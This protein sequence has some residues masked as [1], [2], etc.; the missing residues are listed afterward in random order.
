MK[1]ILGLCSALLYCSFAAHSQQPTSKPLRLAIAGLS[2]GHVHQI[3]N[4]PDKGDI[5][6]V[7]IY[8]SNRKLVD[9]YAKQ[10]GFRE[11][12]VFGDLNRM[13]DTVKPTA[14][15]AFGPTYDH[16][17]V[18]QACA[19]RGIHVMVEKPLAADSKQAFTIEALAKKAGIH[20]LTN[21]ETTWYP[22]T[23]A[24]FD[25]VHNQ[26]GIGAIRKIVV[27][28]GHQGPKEIGVEEEFLAWLTDPVLNGGGAL[29]DFGCYGANLATWLMNGVEPLTVTAVTQQI[30]PEIYSAVDDEATIILKYPN[31]QAIIQ[32]SW[33]WP[34]SRKD[35]DV[36]GRTGAV[37]ALD[38]RNM[39]IRKEGEAQERTLVLERNRA[40]MDDPFAYFA[41]VVRG[42]VRVGDRDLSSLEN[43]VTV[44]RI[45]E[46]AK[47]SAASGTT[48]KLAAR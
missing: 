9:R 35:I 26:P 14:V 36:Y 46:A 22:S 11:D 32:A 28:D 40:P 38:G 8:E 18:V 23:Q 4:R 41:A 39:R 42:E 19:P 34:F 30:K 12:I 16:L 47:Q 6:I 17:S 20:V 45:L 25:L 27:H 33:N 1:R 3:L 13:L 5:Q 37:H 43:N 24:V 44:M 10:Y 7:G 2:H 48:V 21:Y 15:A 31:A 29:M